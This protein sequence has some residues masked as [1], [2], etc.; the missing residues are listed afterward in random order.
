MKRK[1]YVK[2]Q[3]SMYPEYV[4]CLRRDGNLGMKKKLARMFYSIGYVIGELVL[5]VQSTREARKHFRK[6]DKWFN[7]V[8]MST[9]RQE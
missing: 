2:M 7:K 4:E 8:I 9:R 3:N 6:F 1:V 5:F